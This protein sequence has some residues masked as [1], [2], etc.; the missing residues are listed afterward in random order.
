MARRSL[1][2]ATLLAG[3]DAFALPARPCALRALKLREPPSQA[4][5]PAVVARMGGGGFPRGPGGGGFGGGGFDPRDLIGPVV[6]ASLIAS[7]ALGWIFNG[8]LFLS[9][10]PLVAGPIFSWYIQNNLL[11]GSCPECGAPVQVKITPR[12]CS[13]SDVPA[14]RACAAPRP[15]VLKGQQ[16]GCMSCGATMGSDLQNGVFMRY[17]AARR[18]DGVVDIDVEVD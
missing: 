2:L 14:H 12:A 5:A 15:Q 7:G 16:G 10:L 13:A 9:L 18:E 17:G 4:R 3:V 6:F 1:L 11:E 8:I